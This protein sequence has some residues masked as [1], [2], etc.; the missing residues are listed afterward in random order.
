MLLD[1]EVRQELYQISLQPIYIDRYVGLGDL[2]DPVS[3][4]RHKSNGIAEAGAFK[5]LF[6][7]SY[8]PSIHTSLKSY[9]DKALQTLSSRSG[10]DPEEDLY[11]YCPYCEYYALDQVV[12]DG[13]TIAEATLGGGQ[14]GPGDKPLADGS[15]TQV[16]VSDNYALATP[17]IIVTTEPQGIVIPEVWSDII[18]CD[19]SEAGI[20]FQCCSYTYMGNGEYSDP[21]NCT[22]HGGG[23]GGLEPRTDD[24]LECDG[25]SAVYTGH[26]QSTE[27]MDAFLSVVDGGGNEMRLARIGAGSPFTVD[28][29]QIETNAFAAVLRRYINRGR[30]ND[31]YPMEWHAEFDPG[32]ECDEPAQMFVLYE[33]DE[34]STQNIEGTIGFTP[35]VTMTIGGLIIEATGGAIEIG[36]DIEIESDD[37]VIWQQTYSR[38]EYFSRNRESRGCG[39]HPILASELVFDDFFDHDEY[40]R[41]SCSD[42]FLTLPDV[43]FD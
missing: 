22:T 34:N 9:V 26:I 17:T 16:T 30:I 15:Y 21:F 11:F 31:E 20:A 6:E 14:T 3:I 28:D 41:Y 29:G 42:G 7:K 10:D 4:Q 12:S 5:R 40:A 36:F 35:T 2:L 37:D 1:P 8:D 18:I 27:H 19:Q 24:W 38:E 23:G 43:N 39:T 25:F 32:W 33:E 13:F